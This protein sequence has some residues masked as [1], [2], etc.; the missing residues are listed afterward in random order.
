M[1]VPIQPTQGQAPEGQQP[2]AG[3][4]PTA[5]QAGD[6]PATPK[7]SYQFASQQEAEAAFQNMLKE[8]Q[9]AN[10]EAQD[11]N[12]KLKAFED[13]QLSEQQK[14][15]RDL[16]EAKTKAQAALQRAAK[17]D[18]KILAQQLGFVHPDDAYALIEA[19]L[20]LGDDGAATNAKELLEA[21]KVAR[22]QYVGQSLQLPSVSPTNPGSTP[23]Q[24][25][26]TKAQLEDFDFAMKND[27]AI[28]QALRE[29]RVER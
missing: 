1:T 25:Y 16:E 21:L 14:L 15:T 4:A 7:P 8:K 2:Q 28:Q 22:P 5:P 20:Q 10:K 17:A 18:V 27:A 29:G 11:T 19:K 13:A 12:K 9:A 26:F 23:G 24:P 6:G 3:T